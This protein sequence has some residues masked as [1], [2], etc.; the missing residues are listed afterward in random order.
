MTEKN[1]NES[2]SNNNPMDY[3]DY[4]ANLKSIPIWKRLIYMLIFAVILSASRLITFLMAFIQFFIVLFSGR[5][6][7]K[8]EG[9]G[10]ALGVY[11]SEIVDF[12]TYYT[13]EKPFPF[14]K[15][16]PSS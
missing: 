15:E 7:P 5:T 11:L 16:W 12:L 8:I 2:E 10:H 13:D 1:T 3:S 14:D 9:F 4:T 6:N